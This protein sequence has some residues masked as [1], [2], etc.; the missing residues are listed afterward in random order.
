MTAPKPSIGARAA[1]PV[2]LSA[3]FIAAI[4]AMFDTTEQLRLDPYYDSVGVLT[5]CRG[6]TNSNTVPLLGRRIVIGQSWTREECESGERIVLER[7]NLQMRNCTG[8]VPVTMYEHFAYLHFGW[9]VGISAFCNSTLAN[10][11]RARDYRG[12]CDQMLRW[13]YTKGRDCRVQSNN[14]YGL[15]VRRQLEQAI[16]AGEVEIAGLTVPILGAG[17]GS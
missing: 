5:V 13:V 3:A 8:A 14:C 2:A 16:C 17:F 6:L 9:N 7:F 15:V 4:L 1:W 10:K 12:A 11:L